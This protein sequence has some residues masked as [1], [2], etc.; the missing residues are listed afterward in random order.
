[1]FSRSNNI[2]F[3]GGTFTQI[4]QNGAAGF[5]RLQ[6]AA[7]PGAFHNSG[8]RFDSPRCH[9]KTRL[10]VLEK[11]MRWILGSEDRNALIMWLH[12]A[13]GAGKS[14]IAQTIA[15]RCYE[16]KLLIATFFFARSDPSRNRAR[17]LFP[18]IAYQIACTIPEARVQLENIINRDPLIFTRSLEA[19][20]NSLIVEPLQELSISGYFSDP[21]LAPRLIIIDGI[22][23]CQDSRMQCKILE[24][25]SNSF[26]NHHLP[27]IFLIASRPEQDISLT[28]NSGS[29]SGLLTIIPLDNTF[30][31]DDDI[32]L[33]LRDSFDK[34]K[35]T[36]PN[37]PFIPPSWPSSST[38]YS[39][40]EK[41][42]GQFIYSSVVMKY[43]SSLRHR[44]TDRLEVILGLRSAPYD[45]PFAEL[46][47]LYMHIFSSLEVLDAALLVIGLIVLGYHPDMQRISNVEE[48][49]SLNPG[50]V[51][52][53]L[54]DLTSLITWVEDEHQTIRPLHASLGDFLL[55]KSRSKQ[56]YI[57]PR[58]LHA[59]FACHCIQ[60]LPVIAMVYIPWYIAS[61]IARSSYY[62]AK[63]CHHFIVSYVPARGRPGRRH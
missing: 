6:K 41:S 9:P 47:A 20:M 30:L 40:V 61:L 4:E 59:R 38:I 49:L 32:R 57:D 27:L 23:E 18:T 43:V 35:K 7:S 48:F 3:S 44:P 37:K 10:A 34:I 60:M 55:D 5:D 8:E 45:T 56:F 11:I 14:A 21:T 19:Q 52:M 16:A 13:A 51:T 2:V 62:R 33:F 42:S 15:E 53:L 12:G 39:L 36:H 22:D 25:I 54:G 29:L 58:L 46:D 28:F 31:P 24:V 50:D 17:S 1:M 26:R 63:R